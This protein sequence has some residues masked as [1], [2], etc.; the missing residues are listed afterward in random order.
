ME[1]IRFLTVAVAALALAAADD[2]SKNKFGA[3]LKGASETP[4][5]TGNASGTATFTVSGT[6]VS[7]KITAAGLSG[8]ATAAHIHVGPSTVAGPVVVPFPATSIK[9]GTDGS[10]TISGSFTSADIK[11]QTNPTLKTL[12]DLLAQM[13][14]GNTYVN[15]HTAAHPPGE[16]RGQIAPQ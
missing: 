2:S 12:D 5:V 9:N 1:K 11:P 6:S 10:V 3:T 15:I 7:Y 13:R 14:A 16:I 8:N 4:P